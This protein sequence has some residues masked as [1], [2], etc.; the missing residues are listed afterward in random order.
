MTERNG[1]AMERIV[2]SID[3]EAIAAAFPECEVKSVDWNLGALLLWRRMS[4]HSLGPVLSNASDS[5]PDLPLGP[6]NTGLGRQYVGGGHP[7]IL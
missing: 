2:R 3:R 6:I 1:W 7:L 4:G 5:G